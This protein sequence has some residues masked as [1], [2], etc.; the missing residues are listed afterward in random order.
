MTD[1]ERLAAEARRELNRQEL[2]HQKRVAL[3]TNKVVKEQQEKERQ[4]VKKIIIINSQA[5]KPTIGACFL[6]MYLLFYKYWVL[7]SCG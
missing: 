2:M 6:K 1:E 7:F 5:I 4:L 3:E